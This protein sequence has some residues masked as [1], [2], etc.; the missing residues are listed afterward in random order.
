MSGRGSCGDAQSAEVFEIRME[1]SDDFAQRLAAGLGHRQPQTRVVVRIESLL[2][3]GVER[4]ER[5]V[6]FVYPLALTE[7]LVQEQPRG[8]G[9]GQGRIGDDGL[10]VE[11]EGFAGAFAQG[12]HVLSQ[13]GDFGTDA[14]NEALSA[15]IL[16]SQL[17]LLAKRERIGGRHR[18][19]SFGRR[20]R[21]IS[22]HGCNRRLLGVGAAT[23][24]KQHSG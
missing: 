5:S 13:L 17:A 9:D 2:Q 23:D 24:T 15:R 20:W 22:D 3:L 7:D 11:C 18:N 1:R 19:G 21:R 6:E 14:Q 10:D 4:S 12:G 8:N 16:A